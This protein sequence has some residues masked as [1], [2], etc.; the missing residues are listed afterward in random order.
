M[1]IAEPESSAHLFSPLQGAQ[2]SH[3]RN[4][5]YS[6]RLILHILR[7]RPADTIDAGRRALK[8][9]M[10]RASQVAAGG[11]ARRAAIF[12]GPS[13]DEDGAAA[14]GNGRAGG[15]GGGSDDD[16]EYEDFLQQR[17]AS[18]AR[19]SSSSGSE[20]ARQALL[21]LFEL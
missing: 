7:T 17:R 13:D 15:A 14:N 3:P 4:H 1:L 18:N 10:P 19:A 2:S 9:G 11:R 8:R 16:A 21:P 20:G 5:A 6:Y 12:D